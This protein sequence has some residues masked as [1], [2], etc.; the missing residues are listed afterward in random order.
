MLPELRQYRPTVAIG[1]F[2]QSLKTFPA[3]TLALLRIDADLYGSTIAVLTELYDRVAAGGY[4]I[5]D[6]YGALPACRLAVDDF[7]RSRAIHDPIVEI[8]Y[9]G[10]YWIKHRHSQ[11]RPGAPEKTALSHAPGQP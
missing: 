3:T 6:D 9:T 1:W 4:V 7:R 2:E 8:D 10:I 11:G 5:V